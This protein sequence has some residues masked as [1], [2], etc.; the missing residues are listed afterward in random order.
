MEESSIRIVAADRK[1]LD[2]LVPLFDGYRV[3]YEQPSDPE[4]ARTFLRERFDKG[5]STVLL[6]YDGETPAGFVQLY[7]TF[8]S[9]STARVWIL[10]DLFVAPTSRRRGVARML[11]EAAAEWAR[12]RSAL[13][14]QLETAVDNAA[15]KALYESL[16]WIRQ[17]EYDTYVL[18]LD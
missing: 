6:A 17:T 5:D 3:F 14:L 16:G 18:L 2:D 7:P 1:T 11:L 4:R 15:A 13:G 8:S 10:N 12:E 9:V